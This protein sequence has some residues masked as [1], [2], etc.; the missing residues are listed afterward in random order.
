[1]LKYLKYSGLNI[2][3]KLNP[4]HW[5]IALSKGS[6]NDAWEVETSYVI[7][8]LPITIRVWFDNGDW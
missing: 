4:F 6:D 5:R 3:L 7:E 2:T 8:L 1:M